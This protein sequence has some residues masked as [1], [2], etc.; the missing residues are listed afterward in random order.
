MVVTSMNR[1]LTLEK[2]LHS[3]IRDKSVFTLKCP[4]SNLIVKLRDFSDISSD[5]VVNIVLLGSK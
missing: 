5:F 1:H 4:C 2:T 3:M